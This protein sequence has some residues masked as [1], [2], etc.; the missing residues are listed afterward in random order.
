MAHDSKDVSDYR[1]VSRGRARQDGLTG[2]GSTK[3]QTMELCSFGQDGPRTRMTT[4][5]N[6]HPQHPYRAGDVRSNMAR[7]ASGHS[8]KSGPEFVT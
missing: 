7:V 3:K 5:I 2:L 1:R 6:R 8:E 4:H